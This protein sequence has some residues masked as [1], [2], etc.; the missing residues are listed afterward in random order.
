MYERELERIFYRCWVYL[1][2]D[3]EVPTPGDYCVKTIARMSLIVSRGDDGRV[4]VFMNRCRHRG[5]QVCSQNSGNANYF[6]CPYHGWTYRN[7]GELAGVPYPSRYGELDKS[8]FGLAEVDAVGVE[9]GFIFARILPGNDISLVDHLGA[10]RRHLRAF[11]ASSPVGRVIVR[12]GCQKGRFRG[13]WKFVGMDGYHPN[14]VH[15]SMLDLQ[16]LAGNEAAASGRANTDKSP[17]RAWDLGNGHCRLDFTPTKDADF[18]ALLNAGAETD[19]VVAEHIQRLVQ[20]QGEEG[21]RRSFEEG[22]HPH[23]HVW[24]NLQLIGVH[25]R[26]LNPL[27]AGLTQV[28][29]YPALLEGASGELNERRLRGHEYFYGPA[30]FGQVDDHEVFE[31]V[32]NGLMAAESWL[33]LLRG[34][35]MEEQDPDGRFGNITDELTQRGQMDAWLTAMEAS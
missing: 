35:G 19:P 20:A 32:Q 5:G 18:G 6:R 13:N 26:V 3:S 33:P 29:V 7:S 34:L 4:R 31:R 12:S 23:L 14:F 10:A 9:N 25:I 27:A 2:H 17:N 22:Q 15:K 8:A 11:V 21:A 16:R 24:P 28:E 30:G 1:A